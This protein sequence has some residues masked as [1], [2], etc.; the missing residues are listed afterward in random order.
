MVITPTNAHPLQEG[1]A[2]TRSK[3]N[4]PEK[5][6]FDRLARVSGGSAAVGYARVPSPA[7]TESEED[8]GSSEGDLPDRFP[9]LELEGCSSV[10]SS[11]AEWVQDPE[12][13]LAFVQGEVPLFAPRFALR[14]SV[15]RPNDASADGFSIPWDRPTS[16]ETVSNGP[17]PDTELYSFTVPIAASR[18]RTPIFHTRGADHPDSP[19]GEPYQT[20]RIMSQALDPPTSTVCAVDDLVPCFRQAAFMGQRGLTYD[21]RPGAGQRMLPSETHASIRAQVPAGRPRAGNSITLR[22]PRPLRTAWNRQSARG[23]RPPWAAVPQGESPSALTTPRGLDR[24]S[25]MEPEKNPSE[26]L[27]GLRSALSDFVACPTGAAKVLRGEHV[28]YG[29]DLELLRSQLQTLLESSRQMN[30]GRTW[31]EEAVLE[32][33]RHGEFGRYDEEDSPETLADGRG[34]HVRVAYAPS[35]VCFD[36]QVRAPTPHP[37]LSFLAPIFHALHPLPSQLSLLPSAGRRWPFAAAVLS[38]VLLFAGLTF[39]SNLDVDKWTSDINLVLARVFYFLALVLFIAALAAFTTLNYVSTSDTILLAH[40]LCAYHTTGVGPEV[41]QKDEVIK[42]LVTKQHQL[43]ASSKSHGKASASFTLDS[44]EEKGAQDSSGIAESS[45]R[46]KDEQ[47][48]KAMTE[49]LQSRLVRSPV[50]GWLLRQG[51]DQNVWLETHRSFL[52][53]A[54]R[55]RW[56]GDLS[57]KLRQQ[58]LSH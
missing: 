41:G 29:W 48:A 17:S 22:I 56:R 9:T 15:H 14:V 25:L 40:P 58:G 4:V 21:R 19:Q 52:V 2:D 5:G 44:D 30:R 18:T 37:S 45:G 34:E 35:S 31:M 20:N 39:S 10:V 46:G 16:R 49:V 23:L 57:D 51:L 33:S 24:E 42:L 3:G 11:E 36:L 32:A 26:A 38:P 7:S 1:D 55:Q 53:N 6:L 8:G 43:T 50:H 47:S 27:I 28:V 54:F 13:L 12:A